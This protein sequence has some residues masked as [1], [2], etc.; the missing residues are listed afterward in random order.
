MTSWTQE[1]SRR[2]VVPSD[3][4]MWLHSV[5]PDH[6]EADCELTDMTLSFIE[7]LLQQSRE[8][9]EIKLKQ[10]IELYAELEQ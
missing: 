2:A 3:I 1:Q 7:D 9:A 4:L 8:L 6:T 10:A 5:L